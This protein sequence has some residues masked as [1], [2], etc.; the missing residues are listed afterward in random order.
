MRAAHWRRRGD[1]AL[2]AC[3]G[4]IGRGLP[5]SWRR[6][7]AFAIALILTA[8]PA[9]RAQTADG[10]EPRVALVVGNGAYTQVPALANAVS[11]AQLIAG[12]LEAAGFDVMLVENAELDDFQTSVIRFGRRLR[13]AGPEATGLFYYAGHAV[14]SFGANY[15][16]PTTLSLTDQADLDVVAL[17][18]SSILRQANSIRA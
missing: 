14:Q 15:L 4:A 3:R 11:D 1:A 13:E 2:A 18:A 16:L 17:E 7:A 6:L 9:A 12:R 8:H 10:Q 5:A